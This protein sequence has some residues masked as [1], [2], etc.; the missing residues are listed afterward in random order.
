[1]ADRQRKVIEEMVLIGI[2]TGTS[3][4]VLLKTF[5]EA[6]GDE[7]SPEEIEK[8]KRLIKTAYK[9]ASTLG[10]GAN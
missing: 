3:M 8:R 6:L 1:M 10:M 7:L 4:E 9:S 2:G 5:V